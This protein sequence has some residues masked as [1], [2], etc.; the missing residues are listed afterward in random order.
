MATRKLPGRDTARC[1]SPI[2]VPGQGTFLELCTLHIVEFEKQPHHC[3]IGQ[4][5]VQSV[6]AGNPAQGRVSALVGFF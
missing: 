3:S 4:A 6:R 1:A 5:Q 2:E